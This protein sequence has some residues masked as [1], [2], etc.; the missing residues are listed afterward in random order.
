MWHSIMIALCTIPLPNKEKV[1]GTD[2]SMHYTVTKQGKSNGHRPLYAL[3]NNVRSTCNWDRDD[4]PERTEEVTG[5]YIKED[6]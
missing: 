6:G 4:D 2:R 1:M 5:L 3:A